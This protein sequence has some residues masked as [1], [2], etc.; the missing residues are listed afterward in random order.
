MWLAGLQE[1]EGGEVWCL[2]LEQRYSKTRKE[3]Q[4]LQ[5]LNDSIYY[6]FTKG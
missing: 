1:G 4:C 2:P 6:V 3:I 5:R